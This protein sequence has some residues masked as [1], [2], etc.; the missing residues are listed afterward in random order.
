MSVSKR[1][2]TT[3]NGETKEAWVATFKDQQGKRRLQTFDLKKDADQFHA[4][5]RTAKKVLL[6][7]RRLPHLT[8]FKRVPPSL[9]EVVGLHD[10][11]SYCKMS[12][13]Y[14]LCRDGALL[15]V[16]QSVDVITR[17]GQHRRHFDFDTAL[18]MPC[19]PE[20][21]DRVESEFIRELRP[22][23][24]GTFANGRIHAPDAVRGRGGRPRKVKLV[25]PA[26]PA[27]AQL[28][29]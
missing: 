26:D 14:F 19:A 17:F 29:A 22:P 10:L 9:H 11:T 25:P 24:N 18:F 1:K 3:R 21:L 6:V 8:D 4:E 13:V 12:G 15:Y 16:G 7:E 23:M 5:I 20:D 2:W 28:G 27:S